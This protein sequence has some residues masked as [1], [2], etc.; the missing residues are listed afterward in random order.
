M[1]GS[2]PASIVFQD[3]AT[4]AFMDIRQFNPGHTLVVPRRHIADIRELDAETGAAI[5][6]TAVRIARAVD[7]AFPNQGLSI[8]HSVGPA[9][10]QEIPHFHF[11]IHPRL[12]GDGLFRTYPRRPDETDRAT[13]EAYADRLR[14]HL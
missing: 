7:T 14:K 13:L 2:E 3:D 11:H 9:A 8:W 12:L 1:N 5:M 4:V 6:A 10:N